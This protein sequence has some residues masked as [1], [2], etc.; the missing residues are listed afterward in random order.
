MRYSRK[1][2]QPKFLLSLLLRTTWGV[3]SNGLF[4]VSSAY[5]K[6][7]AISSP[8][9]EF[10]LEW[11]WHLRCPE[12]VRFFLVQGKLQTNE[13]RKRKLRMIDAHFVA[14][15][16]RIRNTFFA[17]APLLDRFGEVS[18]VLVF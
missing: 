3:S 8:Q 14:T 17:I 5:H 1:L 9:A 6:I 16:W 10:N 18:G 13:T 15:V 7:V 4:T 2:E 11:V 12:R